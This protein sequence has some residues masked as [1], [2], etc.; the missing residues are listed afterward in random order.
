MSAESKAIG[1]A[2]A[3][4]IVAKRLAEMEKAGAKLPRLIKE[5][6]AIAFS[7]IADYVDVSDDG[8]LTAIPTASIKPAKRKAIKK[9][10]EHTRITESADGEKIWKDSRIEYELYDKL[11]AITTLLKLRNDFPAEKQEITGTINHTHELS[12]ELS[13]MVDAVLANGV[14]SL[15][16]KPKNGNGKNVGKK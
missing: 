5:L 8:S 3:E 2:V 7:D 16:A 12:P 4:S 13:E 9:I 14:L 6:A 11:S 1:E 15:A 10:K